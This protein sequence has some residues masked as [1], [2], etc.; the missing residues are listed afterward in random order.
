[1][2]IIG[3]STRSK[4]MT[5]K[6]NWI[7]KLKKLN[8]PVLIIGMPGIGS[9]GKITVDMIAEQLKAKKI[10]SFFSHSMPNTVFVRENNTVE[11]PRIEIAHIKVAK[12]DFLFLL[13]DIQPTD[14]QPSYSFA[15]AVLTISK[16][17]KV[18]EIIALG[19]IGL[20]ETPLQSKVY[21]IG[22]DKSLSNEFAKL[23]AIDKLYGVV[24]P[25]SGIT[26]LSVGLASQFGLKACAL[27]AE[28]SGAHM[29]VGI[30][31]TKGLIS[32]LDKKYKLG[33]KL[34]DVEKDII[35]IE[36]V[37]KPLAKQQDLIESEN[38]SSDT[39]YIG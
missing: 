36:K 37:L 17:L 19:G 25:I 8:S 39:S 12:R 30:R 27:L 13:G 23:G 7:K 15:E 34:S 9:V 22:N 3:E 24:G 6:I 18:K 38:G 4:Q 10:I 11:L 16:Q 20:P 31:E 2:A 14:E 1:M 21:C 28:T 32:I 33:L 35:K 29:H 5:W 26:G